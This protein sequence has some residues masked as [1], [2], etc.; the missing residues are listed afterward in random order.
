MSDLS[1]KPH[2]T[3]RYSGRTIRIL[4]D[5]GGEKPW[6]VVFDPDHTCVDATG[7]PVALKY[8]EAKERTLAAAKNTALALAQKNYLWS[9]PIQEEIEWRELQDN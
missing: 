5:D 2:C 4:R 1:G 8:P 9:L 7:K 6:R 3:G